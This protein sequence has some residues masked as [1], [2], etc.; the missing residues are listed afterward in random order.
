MTLQ[1]QNAKEYLEQAYYLE[2][3]I[4]SNIKELAELRRISEKIS[5]PNIMNPPSHKTNNG[6][7][8]LENTI[9][10]IVDLEKVIT[11][12]GAK[13]IDLKQ[14]IRTAINNVSDNNQR[15]LLRLKYIEFLNWEQIAERMSY[16]V[17]QIYRIHS[18][19]LKNISIPQSN[20]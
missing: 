16:S 17:K 5:S 9:I 13:L 4:D 2:E 12:E 10:K 1:E 8:A 20:E 11:E 19:A 14:E 18:A 3:L 7:S 6:N 15:L